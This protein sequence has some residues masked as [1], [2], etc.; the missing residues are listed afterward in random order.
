[1][2]QALVYAAHAERVHAV[3]LATGRFRWKAKGGAGEPGALDVT[4]PLAHGDVLLRV[5]EMGVLRRYVPRSGHIVW[6][7]SARF[8]ERQIL[9]DGNWY[10]VSNGVLLA[11]DER[12]G[13]PRWTRPWGCFHCGVAG[14]AG[15]VFVAGDPENPFDGGAGALH[16]LDARTGRT[17]WRAGTQTAYTYG[18]F[19]ALADGRVFVRT[20]GGDPGENRFSI[21]AFR[22]SD[23]KRLW[24][25]PVGRSKRFW[26][27]P[28]AASAELVVYPSEDGRLY[29]LDAKTGALRWT[30]PGSNDKTPPAIVNGLVWAGSAGGRLVALDARDGR[31]LWE[32]PVFENG[33]GSP[34]IAGRFVV[35]GTRDGRLL[36]YRVPA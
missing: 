22:A 33:P 10:M 7:R 14:S 15:R 30:M 24:D 32:S 25:A 34:V 27:T 1:M 36:A 19:P 35:L 26:F 18:S 20:I 29:A 11:H 28:L 9:A 31:R 5:S 21:Q 16:A 17:L 4:Q 3:E 2:R 12:T 13:R 8:P 23:G 6:Q